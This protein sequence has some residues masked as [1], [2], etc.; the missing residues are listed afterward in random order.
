MMENDLALDLVIVIG[1]V[2]AT[3]MLVLVCGRFLARMR[4]YWN[5]LS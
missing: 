3:V 4:D 1:V 5:W 2:L